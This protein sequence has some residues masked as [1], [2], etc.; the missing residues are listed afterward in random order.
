MKPPASFTCL[1]TASALLS[2][3]KLLEGQSSQIAPATKKSNTGSAQREPPCFLRVAGRGGMFGEMVGMLTPQR[4]SP[5]LGC[6]ASRSAR[7]RTAAARRQAT[8]LIDRPVRCILCDQAE[9]D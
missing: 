7:C 9:P 6:G 3:I 2:A 8:P 5:G 1:M 4:E